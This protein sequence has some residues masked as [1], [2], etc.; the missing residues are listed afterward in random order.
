[1]IAITGASGLLGQ[2][3]VERFVAAGQPVV[4]V[5]RETTGTTFPPGVTVRQADVRD[6]FS[7]EEAFSGAETVVHAAA[8]VSFNPRRR[9]EMFNINVN[10]TRHVVNTCLQLGIRQIV[11][12]S[13][14]A[15]LGRKPGEP[16]RESD[17]WTGQ[18]VNDYADSKHEAE[19]EIFRGSEEGIT[20]SVVNPSLILSGLPLHRSS[21]MLF[22]Y[23]WRQRPFYTKGQINYVDV[24][25]V[26]DAVVSLADQPRPGERF[27][28]C[29]G[30]VLF[31][32]FF[33]E[34]ARRWNMKAPSFAVPNGLAYLMGAAE[35]VRCLLTGDEPMVTRQTARF[36]SHSFR[37]DTTRSTDVL[38]LRY[39]SLSETLDWCCAVYAQHFKGNK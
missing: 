25:D 37:Y 2:T 14:V 11:H 16:I 28:L 33:G 29:G 26:A 12:I 21:G 3:L 23:V 20:V 34:V 10:G 8:M 7:L 24:R 1:M 27:T 35:E 4:A 9:N 17:P 6:P 5:V 30:R 13:S 36:A 15:A 32:E 18:Y 31:S 19:M 38:G 22:D 39:R